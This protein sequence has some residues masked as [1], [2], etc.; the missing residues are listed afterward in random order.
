MH[1]FVKYSTL[2]NSK[3]LASFI[4]IL[5]LIEVI[6]HNGFHFYLN[7]KLLEIAFYI[8][9]TSILYCTSIFIFKD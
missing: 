8:L 2:K 9:N 3:Q 7:F 6:P 4:S 1:F 5:I